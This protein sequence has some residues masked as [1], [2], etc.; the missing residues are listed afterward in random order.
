MRLHSA[1]WRVGSKLAVMGFS[2]GGHLAGHVAL[3]WDA[4]VATA[5]DRLLQAAGDRAAALSARPDAAVLS[6][7]VISA[8]TPA[9][10]R[11][12]TYVSPSSSPRSLAR[13]TWRRSLG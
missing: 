13:S 5:L 1:E 4:P 10:S 8:C 9:L 7:P 2:A 12:R 11:A 6:Y 3:A